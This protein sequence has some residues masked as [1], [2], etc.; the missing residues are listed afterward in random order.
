MLDGFDLLPE[1][2]RHCGTCFHALEGGSCSIGAAQGGAPCPWWGPSF[3]DF[4]RAVQD[5]QQSHPGQAPEPR[6]QGS[7]ARVYN[8]ERYAMS[9][10]GFFPAGCRTCTHN[11]PGH[12]CPD[13]GQEPCGRWSISLQF[14][15]YGSYLWKLWDQHTGNQEEP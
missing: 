5:W 14:F 9:A 3:G 6:T 12:P 8:L 15:L 2:P 11:R 4:L 1:G 10:E 7:G 13:P